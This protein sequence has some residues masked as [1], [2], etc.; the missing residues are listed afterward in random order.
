M[1]I[2]IVGSRIGEALMV[3]NST[4]EKVI[5][6]AGC[7]SCGTARELVVFC[8]LGK[9]TDFH[10]RSRRI[11]AFEFTRTRSAF[12]IIT[13]FW[14]LQFAGGRAEATTAVFTNGSSAVQLCVN[15]IFELKTDENV[16][17]R[18]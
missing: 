1:E 8:D 9:I 7:L 3:R 6:A 2:E 17:V 18:V 15:Q 13:D 14:E 5:S 11:D 16:V 10:E 12:K 4:G